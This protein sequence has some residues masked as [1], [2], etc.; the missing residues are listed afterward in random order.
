MFPFCMNARIVIRC[1]ILTILIMASL[2]FYLFLHTANIWILKIDITKYEAPVVLQTWIASW[3]NY[4][5]K[6]NPWRSKKHDTCAFH[7]H[8]KDY[9][10]YRI[11]NLDNWKCVSCFNNDFMRNHKRVVDLSSHAFKQ[12]WSLKRWLINVSIEK[13]K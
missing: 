11:C 8:H 7:D 9:W 4:D 5:L 2:L 12:I 1:F 6:N 10:M 3:Y 13:I